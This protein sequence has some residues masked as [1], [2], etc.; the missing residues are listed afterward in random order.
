M[1]VCVPRLAGMALLFSS[2]ACA[3]HPA[4]LRPPLTM[5]EWTRRREAF[6]SIRAAVEPR[7]PYVA[8]IRAQL[9]EPRIGRSFEARGAVAVDP[10]KAVRIILVGPAGATAL[11]AWVTK[12]RWRFAVPPLDL[13]RRGVADAASERGLPVGFFR[14]WFL[15]PLEGT[16]LTRD[17][18]NTPMF[19][20]L[21]E[22]GAT[23][24]VFAA[25]SDGRACMSAVRR[26]GRM[27]ESLSSCTGVGTGPREGDRATYDE[28]DSGL[29]VEIAVEG[30]GAAPDGEAFVDPDL[31][32]GGGS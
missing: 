19:G 31:V 12:D 7:A 6:D 11:D 4:S 21:R 10:G 23:I 25:V 26:R 3:A 22:G 30:A 13:V 8:R 1:S 16:L 27:H 24:E 14:W 20:I 28:L 29:H 15:S 18:A 32:T 5:Q 17:E 2:T 9:E